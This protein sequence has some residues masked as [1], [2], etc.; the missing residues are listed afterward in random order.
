MSRFPSCLQVVLAVIVIACTTADV[1]NV[2]RVARRVENVAVLIR[3]AGIWT[4]GTEDCLIWKWLFNVVRVT[5]KPRNC[6]GD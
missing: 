3:V 5:I 2:A 4:F 6:H 1:A